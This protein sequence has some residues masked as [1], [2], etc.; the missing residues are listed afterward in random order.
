MKVLLTQEDTD[1]YSIQNYHLKVLQCTL[2]DLEPVP[3]GVQK[4]VLKDIKEVKSK[5]LKSLDDHTAPEEVVDE[6]SDSISKEAHEEIVQSLLKKAD[7]FSEKYLK[8]QMQ[9]EELQESVA[10]REEQIKSE[11]YKEGLKVG[12]EESAQAN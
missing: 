3:Q 5:K 2:P 7:E 12:Q 4:A 6:E 11:A 9:Y 1:R 8:A 10:S